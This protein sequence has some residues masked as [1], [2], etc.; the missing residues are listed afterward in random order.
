[1]VGRNDAHGH[2]VF[3]RYDHGV[4]RHGHDRVEIACGQHVGE[5]A[6]VIGQKGVNQGKLR[7][8]RSFEQKL[9]SVDLY[10]A[11]ALGHRSADAGWR[12]NASETATTGAN[13]FDKSS[14]GHEMETALMIETPVSK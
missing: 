6:E 2:D 11:L 14:L 13:A 1:M 10:L 12:E 4:C 8:Q 3:R 5:I 7:P 9:L